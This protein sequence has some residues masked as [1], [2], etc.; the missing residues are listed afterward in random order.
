[1]TDYLYNS[2]GSDS[3]LNNRK[4]SWYKILFEGEDN[5][6]V[7]KSFFKDFL[8]GLDR[9]DHL[10]KYLFY[11]EQH[12]SKI[13]KARSKIGM[14]YHLMKKNEA[15]RQRY[16]E[17]ETKISDTSSFFFGAFQI[18]KLEF[19]LIE[20]NL[21]NDNFRFGLCIQEDDFDGIENRILTE[22][23][24]S[25]PDTI[26]VSKSNRVE[27]DNYRLIQKFLKANTLLYD[28]FFDGRDNLVFSLYVGEKCQQLANDVIKDSL[29]FVQGELIEEGEIPD[30][31]INELISRYL[32]NSHY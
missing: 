17:A 31:E 23:L 21:I 25:F 13:S 27:V 16:I 5:D 2:S 10:K 26:Q 8:L 6:K 15:L 32:N 20:E 30:N 24:I 3:F 1:M 7:Y 29:S 28:F 11:Y 22:S 9:Q 4:I 18:N 12:V 19:D 14:F